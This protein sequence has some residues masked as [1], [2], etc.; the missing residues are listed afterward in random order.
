VTPTIPITTMLPPEEAPMLQTIPA[1][2]Q[3]TT[4]PQPNIRLLPE[5]LLAYQE[6]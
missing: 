1:A 2:Q 4:V 6:E 5:W 3:W